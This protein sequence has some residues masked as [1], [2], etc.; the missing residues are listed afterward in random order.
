MQHD[1][2]KPR[3]KSKFYLFISFYYLLY[4]I[5]LNAYHSELQLFIIITVSHETAG[6]KYLFL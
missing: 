3:E 6:S 4:R 1:A 5:I 2:V